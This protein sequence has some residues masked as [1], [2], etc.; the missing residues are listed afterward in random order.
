MA[1]KLRLGL[2]LLG[3]LVVVA[4]ALPVF[5]RVFGRTRLRFPYLGQPIS[6]AAYAELASKPGWARTRLSVAPGIELNGLLRRPGS[7]EAPWV[8]FYPGNDESQLRM[9]QLF[10]SRLAAE[11]DWGL[12]VFAYRGYDSSG[13]KSELDGIRAD[14]PEIFVRLCS[15]EG[16]TP[17]RVHI[18]GFS[19]GGHFAVHAARG[20]AAK[21]QRAASLTLLASVD[22]IVMFPRSPWEKLSPG[23]DYQTRPYLEGVPPPVLV[24]QGTADSALQGPDQGRAIAGALGKRAEYLELPGVEHEALLENEPALER[25]RKFVLDHTK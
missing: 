23:D 6:D 21:G 13:G 14:A 2:G 19:I 1:S 12:A 20:V 25:A 3:V 17:S 9:G 11:R 10:L 18:A 8:L 22:D 15:A 16:L 4:A 5:E 7:K 24:L